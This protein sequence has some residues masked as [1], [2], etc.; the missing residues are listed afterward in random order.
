M[1]EYLSGVIEKTEEDFYYIIGNAENDQVSIS[2]NTEK[3]F[4]LSIIN[5]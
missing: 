3:L 5:R 4:T 1:V 2:E